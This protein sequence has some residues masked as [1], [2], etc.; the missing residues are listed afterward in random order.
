M[1]YVFGAKIFLLRQLNKKFYFYLYNYF[2]FLHK[3]MPMNLFLDLQIN[4]KLSIN[5]WLH[6]TIKI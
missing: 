5:K 3:Y 2:L 6:N 4:I 1:K